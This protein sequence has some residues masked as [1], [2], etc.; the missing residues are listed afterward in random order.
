MTEIEISNNE[1]KERK[2]DRKERERESF[3]PSLSAKKEPWES[4]LKGHSDT[5]LHKVQPTTRSQSECR[6]YHS[7]LPI[8][9]IGRIF[10]KSGQ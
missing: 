8:G 9:Q 4:R 7:T 10:K 1:S 2:K 5:M 6:L 3:T